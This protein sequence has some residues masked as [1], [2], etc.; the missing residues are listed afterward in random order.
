[1]KIPNKVYDILKWFCLIALPACST[2]YWSLANIW[3]WPYAEQVTGTIAAVG[4]FLGV[5]LGISTHAYYAE[6]PAQTPDVYDGGEDG[7]V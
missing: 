3:D 6:T 7:R 4:T 5:L 2:L 1:M